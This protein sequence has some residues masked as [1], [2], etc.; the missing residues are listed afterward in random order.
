MYLCRRVLQPVRDHFGR[1]A[2]NSVYRNQELE[3]ALK[4]KRKDWISKSQHTQGC[5]CDIEIPGVATL[6]L[7][8]W[9][10][11]NLEYDQIICECFNA[12]RGPNSGWVHVS[13]VPAGMGTNRSKL[14]SYVMD[15]EQGNYVYV[16]GLRGSLA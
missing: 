10:S 14:L 15:S 4:K 16:N 7:A 8:K 6:D 3:R 12:A 2:P 11:D 13:V 1:F 9:V 5:A